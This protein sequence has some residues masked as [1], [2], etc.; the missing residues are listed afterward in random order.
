MPCHQVQ[1]RLEAFIEG[2][3]SLAKKKAVQNHLRACPDCHREWVE[4]TELLKAIRSLSSQPCPPRV[5]RDVM[6]RTSTH[7]LG[8]SDLRF[9]LG[10]LLRPAWRPVLGLALAVALVL[11]LRPLPAFRPDLGPPEPTRY[12]EQD[13][14]KAQGD[15]QWALAYVHR[16]MVHTQS[17]VQDE[18]I[19][20]QVIH[21][22]RHS[23]DTA[24]ES[25]KER[26]ER[27]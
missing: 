8:I 20:H 19:P 23:V 25:I 12:S 15:A 11:I 24:V 21:P 16:V 27:L 6:E 9:L 1:D 17:I 3:L 14:R 4:A 7:P 18:V 26:G 13:L 10:R 2:D 5:V 22:L